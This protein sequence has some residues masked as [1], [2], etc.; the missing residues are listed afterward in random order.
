[1]NLLPIWHTSTSSYHRNKILG[2]K[3]GLRV[4]GEFISKSEVFK[5]PI[6]NPPHVCTT[7]TDE[8]HK[9]G[10]LTSPATISS[11][12]FNHQQNQKRKQINTK[13][14]QN[15][16]VSEKYNSMLKKLILNSNHVTVLSASTNQ[17]SL[18][19]RKTSKTTTF[20]KTVEKRM[21]IDE[22]NYSQTFISSIGT[23]RYTENSLCSETTFYKYEFNKPFID[24]NST[25]NLFR[26]QTSFNYDDYKNINRQGDLN[27]R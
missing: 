8:T 15:A 12:T 7:S 22:L 9:Y 6:Y 10:L 27:N 19:S 4:N 2:K 14:K 20:I 18:A 5:H 13:Y 23:E 1:M 21:P 11:P 17:T 26:K 24:Y 16:N 3:K 25:L